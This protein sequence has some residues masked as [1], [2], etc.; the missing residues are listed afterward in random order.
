MCRKPCEKQPNEL[1]IDYLLSETCID[2]DYSD[3]D[4][5]STKKVILAKTKKRTEAR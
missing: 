3:D 2:D 5:K 1:D 4:D